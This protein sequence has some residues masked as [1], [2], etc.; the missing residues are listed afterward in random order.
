MRAP[1]SSRRHKQAG[2]ERR[3]RDAT[4]FGTVAVVPNPNPGPDAQDRLRRAFTI[5]ARIL[6]ENDVEPEGG[7]G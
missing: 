2:P 7:G 1:A 5:L 6:H 4:K 3:R